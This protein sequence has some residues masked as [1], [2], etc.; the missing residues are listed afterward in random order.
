MARFNYTTYDVCR[1]QDVI[2]PKT[3][4][5]N[6]MVL[7][8]E[9]DM[10]P[11]GH[12]YIYGKVL[13]IYHTNVIFIGV[14]MVDYTPIRMECLWVWWYEPIDEVSTWDSSTMD[15]VRFPSV[16]HN[17]SFDFLDPTDVLRGCHIIPAFARKRRRPDGSGLSACAGD[18]NDWRIYYVNR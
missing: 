9:N 8:A 1:A 2:N 5:C 11:Q 6:I 16:T 4:H 14:G 7:R 3:S 12:R 18:K 10:G 17:H 13:G 15:R